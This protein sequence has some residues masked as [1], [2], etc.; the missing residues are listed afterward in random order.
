MMNI[1]IV[2]DTREFQLYGVSMQA[3]GNASIPEAM[4]KLLDEVWRE[5]RGKKLPHKGINHVL[6]DR[7]RILFAGV[8]LHSTPD[9]GTVLARKD[10]SF[11]HYAYWK[12]IGPYNQLGATHESMR[13][14][15][16]ASGR[17]H[18]YPYMEIY[19][20]WDEDPY[21]L[22]TEILYPLQL[23]KPGE[24]SAIAGARL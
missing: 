13:Q 6:Y 12:H 5:V 22:Q 7:D 4:K 16:R 24:E 10:I 3:E 21:K 18:T 2:N 14:A 1:T 23:V 19:G 20:H 17:Q 11:Q 15:I 8:E 9:A